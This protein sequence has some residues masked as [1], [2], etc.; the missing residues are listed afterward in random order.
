M[1][2]AG[3]ASDYAT[4]MMEIMADNASSKAAVYGASDK[5]LA[6]LVG[7]MTESYSKI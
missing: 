4:L 6:V 3:V 7:E 5:P 2:Q 1:R